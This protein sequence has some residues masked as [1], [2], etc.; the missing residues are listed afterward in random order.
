MRRILVDHARGR[1]AA[2]RGADGTRL[3]LAEG[4]DGATPAPEV[5][6]LAVD[7]AL[8]RLAAFDVAGARLVDLRFFGG[9]TVE[10]TAEVLGVS[11]ATVKRDWRLARAFLERELAS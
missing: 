7:Q 1:A 6:L 3:S 8:D 5:D 11:T 10:E 4:A 9:L 2:K